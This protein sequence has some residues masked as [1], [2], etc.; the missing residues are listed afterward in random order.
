MV[1]K[2]GTAVVDIAEVPA[3]AS[4]DIGRHYEW[5]PLVEPYDALKIRAWV[6]FPQRLVREFEGTPEAAIA[7]AKQIIVEHDGWTADGVDLP[8][9]DSD[10]FW[11]S[12]PLRVMA[13]IFQ[14]LMQTVSRP[15]TAA[16]SPRTTRGG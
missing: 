1:S 2:N 16:S 4:K 6:D 7:A 5:V 14:T 11:E 12:V 10:D 13:V 9:P 3:V 15:P 8:Q